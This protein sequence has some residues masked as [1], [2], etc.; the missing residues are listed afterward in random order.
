MF[1]HTVAMCLVPE[2]VQSKLQGNDF[3]QV[4]FLRCFIAK[5]MHNDTYF[6]AIF[7]AAFRYQ[8]N[9]RPRPFRAG[10][11]FRYPNLT[12]LSVMKLHFLGGATYWYRMSSCYQVAHRNIGGQF[13]EYFNF[14]TSIQF[15]NKSFLV[16]ES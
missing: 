15:S 11:R 3:G 16:Q 9:V 4:A 13:S 7:I 6:S 5:S 1:R 2:T 8:M 10:S 14:K 12:S